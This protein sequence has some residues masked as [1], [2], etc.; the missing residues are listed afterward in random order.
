M[1]PLGSHWG[2]IQPETLKTSWASSKN[3]NGG[4]GKQ[5]ALSHHY[6]E[7]G[8]PALHQP[9]CHL[10]K[11][12]WPSR[13]RSG[14][15]RLR[16]TRNQES[17]PPCAPAQRLLPKRRGRGGGRAGES[18]PARLAHLRGLRPYRPPRRSPD[19]GSTGRGWAAPGPFQAYLPRLPGLHGP[20]FGAPC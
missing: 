18:F 5:G 16:S 7:R 9:S 1:L 19:Q 17:A 12:G 8:H 4:V 2:L 14:A 3:A 20:A 11:G 13:R 10:A 6:T 15:G